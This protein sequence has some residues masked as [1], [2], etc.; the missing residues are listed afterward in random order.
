MRITKARMVEVSG[1]QQ[2]LAL[3]KE[4]ARQRQE[5]LFGE[6]EPFDRV[7]AARLQPFD[8]GFGQPTGARRLFANATVD[9]Q[10]IIRH[11]CTSPTAQRS[12]F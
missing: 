7:I 6:D 10:D 12:W 9:E 11:R 2:A 1:L 4:I 8:E 5:R 3:P